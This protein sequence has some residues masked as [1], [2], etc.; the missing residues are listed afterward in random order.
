M[1]FRWFCPEGFF[2]AAAV[3]SSD[4]FIDGLESGDIIRP[5]KVLLFS[6]N[7][8]AAVSFICG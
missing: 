8:L 7:N 6:Q 4:L 5:Q 2:I 1:Q 3:I